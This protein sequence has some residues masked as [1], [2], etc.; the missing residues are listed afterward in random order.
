MMAA[1]W[2]QENKK[3]GPGRGKKRADDVDRPF[4]NPTRKEA[5]P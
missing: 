4:K 2:A 1:K 3:A 5:T